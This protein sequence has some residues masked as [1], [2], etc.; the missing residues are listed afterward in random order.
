MSASK[1]FSGGK[2]II[3]L[4][5]II[6]G[7]YL[8][9]KYGLAWYLYTINY[10]VT[11]DAR[12]KGTMVSV[13]SEVSGPVEKLHVD[14]GDQVKAGQLL[15]QIKKEVYLHQA[16]VARAE[17]KAANSRL[18]KSRK[19]LKLQVVRQKNKVEKAEASLEASKG[20][21]QETLSSL[22]LQK[23]QSAGMIKEGEAAL[24]VAESNLKDSEA[25]FQM[26]ESEYNRVIELFEKG[27]VSAETLDQKRAE[28]NSWKAKYASAQKVVEQAKA[29]RQTAYSSVKRVELEERKVSTLSSKVKQAQV[30]L[31]Q[32]TADEAIIGL[33]QDEIRT[34]Q[35]EVEKVK[36]ELAE[37]ELKLDKTDIASPISGIVSKRMVDQ[38]EFIHVGQAMMVIN[39][40][41]DVWISS[42]IEETEIRDVRKGS[43][44]IIKVDA[45]PGKKFHGIVQHV[46]ASAISEFSLFSTDNVTGN[47]TKVTQRIPV[48]IGV[49]SNKHVLRPGMMV[50]VG[51]KKAGK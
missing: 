21:L 36:A 49:E 25:T 16:E 11:D 28:F 7:G 50:V 8:G 23:E 44:V 38:G 32:A 4:V 35:S 3:L 48:K 19:E 15:A 24:K 41:S 47:F 17:F 29:R 10:V 12:V 5:V 42:N 40:I 26:Y 14:E 34:F 13:S 1:K 18:G 30:E 22:D 27:I 9:V 31:Q 20:A 33:K 39:D 6:A 2:G 51:I 46:G 37:A 43:P 45:Y